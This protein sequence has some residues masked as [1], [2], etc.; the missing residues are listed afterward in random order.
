MCGTEGEFGLLLFFS[1][2]KIIITS[3]WGFN[4]SLLVSYYIKKCTSQIQS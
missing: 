4:C 2:R 1:L 3:H